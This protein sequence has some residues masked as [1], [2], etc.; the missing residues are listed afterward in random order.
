MKKLLLLLTLSISSFLCYAQRSITGTVTDARTG[1]PLSGVSVTINGSSRGSST[2][3]TGRYSV[4]TPPNATLLFSI[5]GYTSQTINSGNNTQVNVSM[6]PAEQNLQEVIV[7]T[8]YTSQTRRQAT[9]SIAK[10]SGDEVKSQ[11]IGSFE[12]LLQGKA[13]GILIQSQSGQP[14]SSATVTIRGKGSVLGT[15]EPLYIL[16]GVQI[17]AA[18]FQS[19]NPSDIETYNVLKDA[20]GTAQYGSRGAN[21]VIVITTKRGAN[22]K[23]KVNYDVQYG[24][25]QLPENKLELMSSADKINYEYNYDRPLYGTNPFGWSDEEAD[26]LSNVKSNL[27]DVLFRKGRTIQHQL[28]LAGGNDKTK[29]FASGSIFDQQ[30]IVISTGL[31]RLTGRINLDHNVG[32]FKVGMNGFVGS[33]KFT[34]TNE[35]DQYIGSPLNAIRWTNP[36]VTPYLPDGSYNDFDF[37]LQGQ[38]N[39][40]KELLE[41]P[42]SNRQLKMIGSI[43]LE[44]R[45]PFL[46]GLVARTNWGLDYT[47][48]DNQQYFDRNTYQGSQQTGAQGS[49]GQNTTRT[50][51]QTITTSLGYTKS[52]RDHAFGLTLF[53]EYIKTKFNGFGY[54]GFGL[55]G[56]FKNGAGI[57]PGTSSNG[58]IPVV[59]SNATENSILSYFAIGDYAYKKRYFINGTVRRDGSSRLAEGNKWTTFGAI[60]A[61]WLVSAENFMRNSSIIN[62]LKLKASYGSSANQ[63]V[64]DSYEAL[65]QFGPAVYNGVGG[66]I[67]TNLKKGNL[68]W[69]VR[70]SLNIGADFSI[71][72]NRISGSV[73]YYDSKTNGLYLNR[74]LSGTNGVYSILTNL[75]K[76]QNKGIELALNIA[77]VQTKDFGWNI[78]GNFTYNKNTILQLDGTNEIVDGF[79][80]N[81]VGQSANSVFLVKYAGVDP[82]TGEALYYQRDG[83]TTTNQYDPNDK[84]IVGKFDPPYFGGLTTSVRFKA[85]EASVLFTYSFGNKVF[86]GDRVNVENPGYWYSGLS[87]DMLNE[88]RNPGDVTNVPSSFNDFQPNT[89]RFL[90]DGKYLRLR[91]VTLSYNIPT[92][93]LSKAK[94]NSA[95]FFVQG[96]NLFVWSKFKGYDPEIASGVLTGAQY[97]ALKAIT[98]GLNLGF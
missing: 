81:K 45:F 96:Q 10:V 27:K 6:V 4:E 32:N 33:S 11:P 16:D 15:T 18:D 24:A 66:L 85:L 50:N 77:V 40:V 42:A 29:F 46:R 38:P 12:Q 9:S 69:E 52:V 68:T 5:I 3:A 31:R 58:F 41:N 87:K 48:N 28:S 62:E 25:S 78:G 97:P 65:E 84:V 22:Q 59:Q 64:G 39:P 95:R 88:W 56:P 17:T 79:A 89:T 98:V 35:N 93:V 54:T 57:T 75:G 90:E 80:I 92:E 49:F 83:K 60:G 37:D 23:T 19:I 34:N 30:G 43:N 13:P 86:N 55:V 51:R 71:L 21:G 72:K 70:R 7:S 53:N 20:M 94:I 76:M 63:G 14:G 1:T 74:Q 2:D 47:Q 73:E 67:L 91:N 82:E 61:G 44:Y 26:S 36:Y 8:G